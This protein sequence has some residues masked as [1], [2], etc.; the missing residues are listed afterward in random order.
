M[1]PTRDPSKHPFFSCLF[2]L[3]VLFCVTRKNKKKKAM[4]AKLSS[5]SSFSYGAALQQLSVAK[6]ATTT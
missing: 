4:T 3:F 5:P 6:K 1:G 2:V